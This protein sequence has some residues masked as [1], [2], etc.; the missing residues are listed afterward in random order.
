MGDNETRGPALKVQVEADLECVLAWQ[1]PCGMREQ[2]QEVL[3][4]YSLEGQNKG[5]D[6]EE[7]KT[8]L[9]ERLREKVLFAYDLPSYQPPIV[10]VKTVVAF[11][12]EEHEGW[13]W[14]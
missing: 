4:H 11:L 14:T 6:E 5:E 12:R 10:D 1:D 9:K 13:L 2:M 7:C 3:L 8:P